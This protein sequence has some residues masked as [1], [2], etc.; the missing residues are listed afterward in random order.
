MK[1][2]VG[3]K[4]KNLIFD[5]GKNEDIDNYV[6][7]LSEENYDP[8]IWL[9]LVEKDVVTEPYK[10]RKKG[11]IDSTKEKKNNKI[12]S[13]DISNVISKI[14]MPAVA[15]IVISSFGL[16]PGLDGLNI[17]NLSNSNRY[18]INE[19]LNGN[20]SADFVFDWRILDATQTIEVDNFA[21]TR[22]DNSSYVNSS[23]IA[24]GTS[25]EFIIEID[26]SRNGNFNRI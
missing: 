19:D 10:K 21:V 23:T 2:G 22:K 7:T 24:P 8:D 6:L 26:A 14:I 3:M 1:K 9:G 4:R 15:A 16:L 11:N 20:D 18:S 5:I 12:D 13:N 17:F 25:G